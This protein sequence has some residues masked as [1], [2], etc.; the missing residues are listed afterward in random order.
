MT[1]VG[2]HASH[3]QIP[4]AGLLRAVQRAEEAGFQAAMCSDHLAPWGHR[5]GESGH[6]WTWLG[7]ALQ[8][9]SLPFGV[10][11]AP[12]QRY[13]P[14]VLAQAIGTLESMFP[15]RFWPAIGSGEAMNEHVTGE[16]WPPKPERDARMVECVDVI[17]RLLAGDEVS[18][19]G[20]VRVDRARVWSR[21]ASPPPLVAAAV[22]AEKA[23]SAATWADG[24]ITVKQKPAALRHVIDAY[25]GAGGRGPITL[26]VHLSYAA[27]A[28][29]ALAIAHDQWRNG[30][31][32]PPDCWDIAMPSEFDARVADARPAEVAE[33][34]LVSADPAE[35]LDQLAELVALGFD[36]VF[37]HHVGQHQ[38][39]FIDVFGERVVPELAAAGATEEVPR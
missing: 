30:L 34:V 35:H 37:L 29:E 36:R 2:Y 33:T 11:T 22:S 18:H 21:P 7:A 28:D 5:Q 23:A 6:A 20:L 31:V 1:L 17:R 25:R 39:A 16:P 24:L 3:E 12:G 19:D 8:A 32:G 38:D 4:P 9:T 27:T 10:V 15:G 26:Q 14:V 13:H